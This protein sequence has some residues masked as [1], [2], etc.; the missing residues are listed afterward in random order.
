MRTLKFLP[1]VLALGAMPLPAAPQQQPA[2]TEVVDKIVSQEQVEMQSLRQYSP[3]VET[4]IQVMHPTRI[5]ARSRRATSIFS[6][7]RSSRRAS[8]SS[9]C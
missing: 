8:S 4:Y 9:R 1:L 2:L 3:I 7:G 6:G 5:S